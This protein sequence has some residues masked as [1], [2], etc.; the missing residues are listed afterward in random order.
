MRLQFGDARLDLNS[1]CPFV[2]SLCHT[3]RKLLLC[4]LAPLLGLGE[5]AVSRL[6]SI[7]QSQQFGIYGR[8]GVIGRS[9]RLLALLDLAT[10]RFQLFADRL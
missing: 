8:N 4:R 6:E 9:L 1:P 2:F 3:F 7:V 10:G 5:F